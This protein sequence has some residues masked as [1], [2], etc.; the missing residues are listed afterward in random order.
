ML[1]WME[2]NLFADFMEFCIIYIFVAFF[3][4]FSPSQF[5]FFQVFFAFT[6]FS[7]SFSHFSFYHLYHRIFLAHTLKYF[8][9][10]DIHDGSVQSLNSTYT[11]LRLS[12]MYC[13]ANLNYSTIRVLVKRTK[14]RV[15]WALGF[16]HFVIE[17]NSE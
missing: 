10:A 13:A 4:H 16:F 11:Q 17:T 3:S 12:Y 9:I 6:I 15:K 1:W 14:C 8:H 5:V 7:L 2:I